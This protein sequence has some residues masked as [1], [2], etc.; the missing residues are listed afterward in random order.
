MKPILF[1]LLGSMWIAGAACSPERDDTTEPIPP[2]AQDYWF[3]SP[4]LVLDEEA[5]LIAVTVRRR[6]AAGGEWVPIRF[7]NVGATGNDYVFMYPGVGFSDSAHSG[8][9]LFKPRVDVETEPPEELWLVVGATEIE[10]TPEDPRFVKVEIRDL[11]SSSSNG[12]IDLRLE[13]GRRWSFRVDGFSGNKLWGQKVTLYLDTPRVFAGEAFYPLRSAPTLIGKPF[14]LRQEGSVLR[15][16]VTVDSAGIR[17]VED[18]VLYRKLTASFPWTVADL[19]DPAGTRRILVD[20]DT[21]FAAAGD[22]SFVRC[23]AT[24]TV[25]GRFDTAGPAGIHRGAVTLELHY[26]DYVERRGFSWRHSIGQTLTLTLAD[27]VGIVRVDNRYYAER[28]S[29]KEPSGQWSSHFA[30]SL[31]P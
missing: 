16:I 5:G 11:A 12:S 13:A 27:T 19:D 1:L 23:R 7:I 15:A 31:V 26:Q 8:E 3:D 14:A 20:V 6:L 4:P 10:P 21:A 28:W 25:L 24:S 30:G 2:P 22:S 9:F 17:K 18:R 29:P